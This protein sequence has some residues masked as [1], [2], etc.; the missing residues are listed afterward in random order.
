MKRGVGIVFFQLMLIL[1]VCSKLIFPVIADSSAV[2]LTTTQIN[3][4]DKF[5][6]NALHYAVQN[7]HLKAVQYLI[8]NGATIN[9]KN[10]KG[11]TPLHLACIVSDIPIAI[12]L[13]NNKAGV[14]IK[15]NVV[16][17]VPIIIEL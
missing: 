1:V 12:V 16:I 7:Q 15:N 17:A 6:Q 10:I 8:K 5:G 14:N 2:N 11:N 4:T 3:S 9:A 13:L